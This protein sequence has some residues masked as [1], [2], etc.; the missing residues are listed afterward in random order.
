MHI[1][2][3][4]GFYVNQKVYPDFWYVF[5]FVFTLSHGQSAAE[6]GFNI[7]RH[8]LVDNLK[9]T[10]LTSLR[11]VFDEIIHHGSIRSFVIYNF[12]LL[13]CNS[14]GTRYKNDLAQRRKESANIENKQKQ[15]QLGEDL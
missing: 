12:L 5:K 11:L 10:N 4:L 6:H 9:D 2:D 8:T 7:N 15:K 13:S 1:D 14:A 3:F